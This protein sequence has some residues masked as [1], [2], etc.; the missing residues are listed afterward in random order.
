MRTNHRFAAPLA[1]AGVACVAASA[2]LAVRDSGAAHAAET[3]QSVAVASVSERAG[4]EMSRT[5]EEARV[6]VALVMRDR[7]LLD[8][9]ETRGGLKAVLN[10]PTAQITR[11][12]DDVVR[13][14]NGLFAVRRDLVANV[15]LMD[16]Q[17]QP[18]LRIDNGSIATQGELRATKP[19]D[20][21]GGAPSPLVFG[22]VY[23]SGP[24]TSWLPTTHSGTV[25]RTAGTVSGIDKQVVGYVVVEMPTRAITDRLLSALGRTT[26]D[27]RVIDARKGRVE[28]RA[29]SDSSTTFNDVGG[30]DPVFAIADTQTSAAGEV[31]ID[32]RR[33][34]FAPVSFLTSVL[35]PVDWSAYVVSSQPAVATGWD[36]QSPVMILLFGLG[37]ALILAALIFAVRRARAN[38]ASRHAAMAARDE[39]RA[40]LDEMSSALARVADGDLGVRLPVESFDDEELRGM[41]ASF[42]STL[43]RLRDLVAQ[44]QDQG[45]T[46]AQ[47]SVELQAA[48]GQQAT[49][50]EQQAS[51]VAETTATIEELAATAGQI[52]ATSEQ[53]SRVATDTLALT[54]EGRQAVAA[55]VDAMQV[56]GARVDAIGERAVSL[57]DTGR[58]IGRILDVIDELAERT[59]LLALNAAIEAARAGEHGRG[60]AV[61]A[62]EIRKLAERAKTSTG[63]IQGL[64]ARIA[65]ESGQTV[66]ASEEGTH[67][68]R[69]AQGVAD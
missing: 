22:Q 41:A 30:V 53:V 17:G 63:E 15:T 42:D 8:Y 59:N 3:Q 50:A 23:T 43:A 52:A 67:E 44:V 14:L 33:S 49:A 35:G 54:E 57:G 37:V 39:M 31:V 34:S 18:F 61:V 25:V 66:M 2:V 21:L 36:S 51:G 38:K 69:R 9:L 28:L 64:V 60:F 48:S 24:T 12:H 5:V 40:R 11:V 68:V 29:D 58:E 16:T 26:G 47:A 1:L 55:S 20:K 27:V 32:G 19:L 62:A 56:V 46:L 65:H 7:S 6:S 10:S 45:T 4:T 13:V